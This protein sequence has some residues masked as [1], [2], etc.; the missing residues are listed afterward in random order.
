ME[1]VKLS[2]ELMEISKVDLIQIIQADELNI[3][4]E[5]VTLYL[6]TEWIYFNIDSRKQVIISIA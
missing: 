1:V 6:I 4:D 5:T 3:K 2:E